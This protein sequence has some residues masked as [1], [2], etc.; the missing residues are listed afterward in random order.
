MRTEERAVFTF[1]TTT[2]AMHMEYLCGKRNLPGRMIPVPTSISAGCGLAWS[3]PPASREAAQKA[4]R[5]G[6]V[7]VEAVT[8][9]VL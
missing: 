5:E 8:M 6:G 9:L 7:R 1:P 4:A 2:D 3:A